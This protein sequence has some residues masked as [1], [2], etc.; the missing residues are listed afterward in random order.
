MNHALLM[1]P[2]FALILLGALLARRLGYARPFWDGAERL[3]YYV[4]FPALLFTS[5]VTAKFSFATES[6]MLLAAVGAFL[7]AAVLGFAARWLLRPE[8]AF[9][10]SCVQTAFRYNSYIGLAFAQSL[11]GARGVAL[12]ALIVAICVPLANTFAVFALAKHRQ[13]GV[14]REMAV[15][16]LILATVSGLIANLAGFEMP[17]LIGTFLSR[18]GGASLALGLLCIGAGLSFAS[19]R[20]ERVTMGYF[21]AIKLVAMPAV[22]LLAVHLLALDGTPA[23]IVMLFAA[24]PTASSAYILAARMGGRAAPVAYAITVQTLLAMLTLPLW[25]AVPR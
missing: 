14:L 24:L 3:V 15:N 20:E 7:A 25:L 21:V 9:F 23:L 22:A 1:L 6:R 17:A 4:L 13:T 11:A 18:L 8:P 2:D 10:A 5:I 16:P 12:M 19:V